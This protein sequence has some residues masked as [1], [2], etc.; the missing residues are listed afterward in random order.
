VSAIG[1]WL[2]AAWGGEFMAD[3]MRHEPGKRAA[4]GMTFQSGLVP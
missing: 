4:D 2:M 3:G 1:E